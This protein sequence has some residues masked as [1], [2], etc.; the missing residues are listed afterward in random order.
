MKLN[1]KYWFFGEESNDCYFSS[2]LVAKVFAD[3]IQDADD[4]IIKFTFWGMDYTGPNC[5][6]I[7]KT[8][9]F[10]VK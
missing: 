8:I 9:D 1:K 6:M 7:D 4:D 2:E 3:Q 10:H 5:N